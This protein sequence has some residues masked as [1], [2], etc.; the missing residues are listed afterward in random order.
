MAML[1]GKPERP[2][3]PKDE[4]GNP[5]FPP[6]GPKFDGE[7]PEPPKDENG[8]PIFPPHGPKPNCGKCDEESTENKKR[9]DHRS[10]S[11]LLYCL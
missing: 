9:A 7:R 2:E 6:H 1:E 8:N 10:A 4:N 5:I 11:T 3:L